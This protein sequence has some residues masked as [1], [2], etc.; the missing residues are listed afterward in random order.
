MIVSFSLLSLL[1]VATATDP[2][3]P[4]ASTKT[5]SR[6]SSSEVKNLYRCSLISIYPSFTNMFSN[7]TEVFAFPYFLMFQ[8]AVAASPVKPAGKPESATKRSSSEVSI[9]TKTLKS[10]IANTINNTRL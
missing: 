8:A 3:K 5:A 6:S 4:A 2:V 9:V 10:K 1:Q 7:K